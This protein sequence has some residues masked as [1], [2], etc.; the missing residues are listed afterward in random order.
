PQRRPQHGPPGRAARP[1]RVLSAPPRRPPGQKGKL[2]FRVPASS[3]VL[4]ALALGCG[5]PDPPV[6]VKKHNAR[7]SLDAA[8]RMLP[9]ATD[10]AG[11]RSPLRLIDEHVA[12]S[13]DQ[14]RRLQLK[15]E[16]K[17]RLRDLCGLDAA[18]LEEV[19][20]VSFR[21]LDAHHLDLCFLLRDTAQALQV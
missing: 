4:A 3:L 2:M 11:F 7:V 6:V 21:P 5:R 19:E 20:S 17:A 1:G 13:E 12:A 9:K 10:A 18:E 16:Q 8:P 14:K 15:P